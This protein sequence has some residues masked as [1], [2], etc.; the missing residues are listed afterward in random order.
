MNPSEFFEQL[1]A[2]IAKYALLCHPFY[3]S[4]S[5]GEL[6]RDDI[7]ARARTPADMLRL[8][9]VGRLQFPVTDFH[10]VLR[11]RVALVAPATSDDPP[12]TLVG[13]PTGVTRR[14]PGRAAS[15]RLHL[16]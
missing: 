7:R 3:E 15:D 4:W 2:R 11:G 1:E 5:A 9:E 14:P 13:R 12:R 10:D 16:I 6:S 8:R